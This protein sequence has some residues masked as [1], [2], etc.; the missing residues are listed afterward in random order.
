[1]SC[2]P[3]TSGRKPLQPKKTQFEIK[4]KFSITFDSYIEVS[5]CR[6]NHTKSFHKHILHVDACL[7]QEPLITSFIYAHENDIVIM[8]IKFTT[9]LANQE[10]EY[11]KECLLS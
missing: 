3:M 2:Y 11:E 5:K 9:F 8:S 7:A 1:M 6:I 10:K 4:K